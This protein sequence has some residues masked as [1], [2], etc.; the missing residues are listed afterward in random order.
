MGYHEKLLLVLNYYRTET[1]SMVFEPNFFF[2]RLLLALPSEA[3]A[4]AACSG[5]FDSPYVNETQ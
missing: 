2:L 4:V 1:Q 5:S 3:R